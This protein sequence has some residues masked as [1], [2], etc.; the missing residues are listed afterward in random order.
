MKE[1]QKQA[2]IIWYYFFPKIMKSVKNENARLSN[3]RKKSQ[4]L[5]V[6]RASGL[7]ATSSEA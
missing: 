5:I 1:R 7:K 6:L 4:I 2:M 3:L